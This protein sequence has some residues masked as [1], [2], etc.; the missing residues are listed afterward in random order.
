MTCTHAQNHETVSDHAGHDLASRIDS[1]LVVA[2][3]GTVITQQS[4]SRDCSTRLWI[5]GYIML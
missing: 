3:G 1:L 5:I 2:F 4:C